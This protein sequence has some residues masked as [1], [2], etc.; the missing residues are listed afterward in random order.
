MQIVLNGKKVEAEDG[1]SLTEL[2][3]MK[4]LEPDRVVVEVNFEIAKKEDW[5][6]IVLKEN[7]N[8][9][10]LRFVGGG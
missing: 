5:D 8:L 1:A 3:R 2:L 4:G 10:V 9:E 7:D 6:K